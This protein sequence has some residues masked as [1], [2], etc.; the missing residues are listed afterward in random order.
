MKEL[1][2]ATGVAKSTILFYV[3]E[4]LLPE[5]VRPHANMAFY[6]P[7]CVGRIRWIQT[8]QANYRLSLRE[9]K[10][11]LQ[12]TRLEDDLSLQLELHDMIFSQEGEQPLDEADFRDITGLSRAA[13][14]E[15][16]ERGLL[17]PRTPG[18][19]D[20]GDVAMGKILAQQHDLGL[21][22]SDVQYY[23][24]LGRQIVDEE[25]A[26][27]QRLTHPLSREEDVA[28]TML[29]V[30]H[31]RA[32]R[33]YVIDRTFQQRIGRMRSLKDRGADDDG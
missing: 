5:P 13:L 27:R 30:R 10:R 11:L 28:M 7:Q 31:A 12:D 6:A 18:C 3:R 19:F 4:G 2:E 22:P 24:D 17:L 16:L 32:M 1:A 33:T 15:L 21:A 23:V 9:I 14:A 20:S 8:A 26:L 29:L 25:I